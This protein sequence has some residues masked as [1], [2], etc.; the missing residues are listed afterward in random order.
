MQIHPHSRAYRTKALPNYYDLIL[1]FGN[2]ISKDLNNCSHQVNNLEDDVL[3]VKAGDFQ[4]S[5]S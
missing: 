1:I 5:V 3:Q 2:E 4:L